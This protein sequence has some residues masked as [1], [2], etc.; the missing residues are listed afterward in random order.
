ME[1]YMSKVL[2]VGALVL[3]AGCTA[4]QT[5]S[6]GIDIDPVSDHIGNWNATLSPQNN[7]GVSGQVAARSEL[8]SAGISVTIWGAMA[9][10]THPWHVHR[11]TCGNDLGIVGGAAAYPALLVGTNGTSSASASI[12]TALS[13]DA[14]YFVN[15]HKSPT[16]LGTIISCGPLNH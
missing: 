1:G 9:G 6:G 14:S 7:S 10:N 15:I 11:G 2:F 5:E 16:E 13:E 8:T 4:R 12:K 3:M